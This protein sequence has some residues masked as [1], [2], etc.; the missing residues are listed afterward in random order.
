MHSA[1][2]A[3]ARTGREHDTRG[4][5]ATRP[6]HPGEGANPISQMTSRG[7]ERHDTN[8]RSG[9][10]ETRKRFQNKLIFQDQAAARLLDL[11]EVGAGDERHAGDR[12]IA[13][14]DGRARD[15]GRRGPLVSVAYVVT[16]HRHPEQVLRLARTL[17]AGSSDAQLLIHHDTGSHQRPNR[18]MSKRPGRNSI[19]CAIL[20]LCLELR[21]TSWPT[22]RPISTAS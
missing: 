22:S 20:S 17:R 2:E 3:P 14:G 4:A 9:L 10:G 7:A 21:S 1:A 13:A 12:K 6:P 18:P 15:D 16:S 19:F 11:Y 5:A 8:A